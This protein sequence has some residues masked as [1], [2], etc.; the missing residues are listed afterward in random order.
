MMNSPKRATSVFLVSREKILKVGNW[1]EISEILIAKM[2]PECN[3]T[4]LYFYLF[5]Y[6]SR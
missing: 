4:K 1:T 6:S 3:P 5:S 2:K